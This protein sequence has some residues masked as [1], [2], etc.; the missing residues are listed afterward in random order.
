LKLDGS[1]EMVVMELQKYG[2][3][4]LMVVGEEGRWGIGLLYSFATCPGTH[5]FKSIS[6]P[7]QD[8]PVMVIP[9][10]IFQCLLTRLLLTKI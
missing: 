8:G 7:G 2:G 9:H 1:N 6:C 4:W 5:P 10:N 3:L